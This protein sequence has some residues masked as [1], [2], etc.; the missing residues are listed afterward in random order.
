MADGDTALVKR[1]RRALPRWPL[2]E[3]DP[4]ERSEFAAAVDGASH[5][6]DLDPHWQELVLAAERGRTKDPGR[7]HRE[8]RGGA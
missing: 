8:L 5:F 4:I 7:F 3:L 6:D 2:T 1:V